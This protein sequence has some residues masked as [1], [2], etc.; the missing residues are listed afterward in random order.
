MDE[1]SEQTRLLEVAF[2]GE[3][4]GPLFSEDPLKGEAGALYEALAGLDVSHAACEWPFC[5]MPEARDSLQLMQRGIA[6]GMDSVATEY[7]RLFVGPAKKIVP[8]WG[9]VY[10]DRE[11]VL[12][13]KSALDL[14]DWMSEH[15]ISTAV[16]DAMPDDHIGRMLSL[17]AWIARRR[18]EMLVEYLGDHLLI[19]APHLLERLSAQTRHCFF[20]GMGRLALCSLKG[21]EDEFDVQVRHVRLY[22]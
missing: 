5:P 10:T 4:L 14:H 22:R 16:D 15:A 13:G 17:M 3:T 12:F 1:Y 6:Q 9:S 11:G 18:P 21:I 19:W 8:P 7:R 2:V 20:A